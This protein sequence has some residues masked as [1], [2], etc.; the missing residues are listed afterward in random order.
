MRKLLLACALLVFA[1][2]AIAQPY[3]PTPN[4]NYSAFPNYIAPAP[5]SNYAP[6]GYEWREQRGDNDWRNNTWREDRFDEDWRN[7]NWQTQRELQNWRQRQDY[8]KARNPDNPFDQGYVECGK[9]SV[10]SSSPCGGYVKESSTKKMETRDEYENAP[11]YNKQK[12]GP[13]G[14]ENCGHGGIWRRC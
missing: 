10:G 6:R 9:G 12:A 14:V 4:F 3:V 13:R 1:D 2:V 7:R 11:D 8:S 5:P